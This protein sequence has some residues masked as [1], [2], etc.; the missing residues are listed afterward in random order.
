MLA[1]HVLLHLHYLSLECTA[2]TPVILAVIATAWG[3][4]H[5]GI[6]IDSTLVAL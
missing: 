1:E 2:G 4:L 6:K 5:G 3:K